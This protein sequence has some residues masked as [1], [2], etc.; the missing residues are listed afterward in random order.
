MIVENKKWLNWEK[1]LEIIK[2]GAQV[3]LDMVLMHM[4]LHLNLKA[5]SIVWSVATRGM[6]MQ[7]AQTSAGYA[8]R[9][10]CNQEFWVIEYS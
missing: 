5:V 2:V 10:K 4:V 7:I 8:G 6:N 1:S 9:A 3:E